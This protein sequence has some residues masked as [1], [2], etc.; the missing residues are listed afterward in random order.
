MTALT[1]SRPAII[2]VCEDA[3]S[4]AGTRR[5]LERWFASDY[6]IVDVEAPRR[7]TDVLKEL[8]HGAT[9]LPGLPT[10]TPDRVGR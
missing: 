8:R 4:R 5:A 1:D 2:V 7:V 10:E 3:S 9:V 6:R